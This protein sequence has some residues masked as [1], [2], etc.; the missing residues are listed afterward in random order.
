MRR[1]GMIITKRS[2]C[3]TASMPTRRWLHFLSIRTITTMYLAALHSHQIQARMTAAAG[4]P[5][6]AVSAVAAM[7]GGAA[8]KMV[9]LAAIPARATAAIPARAIAAQAMA[10]GAAFKTVSLAAIPAR[11][12][13]AIP[14]AAIPARAIRALAIA[15]PAI[16][17]P[18]IPAREIIGGSL[19]AMAETAARE[20]KRTKQMLTPMASPM[21]QT[22]VRT[23]TTQSKR[24]PTVMVS[25]MFVMTRSSPA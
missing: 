17:V 10:G 6:R 21:I 25:G 24:T 3:F 9:S 22:T 19:A 5:A 18:A 20:M 15:V 8:F 13:A 23:F 7:A 12:T 1:R 4:I 16:A 14:A 2:I 11:T